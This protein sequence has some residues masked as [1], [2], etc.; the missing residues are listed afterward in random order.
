MNLENA[1]AVADNLTV[2][3]YVQMQDDHIDNKEHAIKRT[4]IIACDSMGYSRGVTC[5]WINHWITREF[6]NRKCCG[7]VR[8]GMD[9]R[10][11]ATLEDMKSLGEYINKE[12]RSLLHLVLGIRLTTSADIHLAVKQL[13][14]VHVCVPA[15]LHCQTCAGGT[16]RRTILVMGSS[17][18]KYQYRAPGT[19][20][21]R[22]NR[23]PSVD[24]LV[25]SYNHL[26]ARDE[27]IMSIQHR[28]QEKITELRKR[29]L[30]LLSHHR[31]RTLDEFGERKDE[32]W[33]Q[34][35][36]TFC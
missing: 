26:S 23:Q 31:K 20:Y 15:Q 29:A 9:C 13:D 33:V 12:A 32:G 24:S 35:I 19:Q 34:F 11:R 30:C 3:T 28:R 22:L 18:V 2:T 21:E 17:Y 14:D 8:L 10:F 1:K 25:W 6:Q 5:D 4:L 7:D 16:C 36:T 27:A